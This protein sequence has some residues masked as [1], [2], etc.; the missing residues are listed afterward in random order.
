MTNRLLASTASG[1]IA[2]LIA[3][4]LSAQQAPD[5]SPPSFEAASVK[6]NKSG[7]PGQ[8]IRRQPGGRVSVTNMPVRQ[9]IVFAY[10]LQP[11]QVI[12]G[13]N[14]MA[15]DRFD[16]VAKM[17][18]D[19]APVMPGSGPDPIQLAMRTLLADRF[20]LAA[21]KETR[22]L[23]VYALVMAKPGGKPGP[24]L[25]PSTQDCS[26]QALQGRRGSPPP[27]LPGP[28]GPDVPFLC[29]MRGTPGRLQLGGFPLSQ[30]ANGLQGLAGRMIIDRTG[31]S[32]NWDAE[33][34][35]M[36]EGRGLPPGAPPPGVELPPIDPNAPTLFTA[37]QEQLGLK[38]ESTKAPVEVLVID[39]V[40]QPTPD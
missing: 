7:D 1:L 13:P 28:P 6:P 11:A 24:S 18:G 34:T 15:S 30:L 16:V 19:P 32:G 4:V 35:F 38:L 14:W 2:L 10:Q 17:E 36:P 40:Q 26:P 27:G 29:G 33:L 12:G 31:L 21:H 22:D 25:K 5:P 37:L 9:L 8:F 20:K 23:D 3:P 39:S